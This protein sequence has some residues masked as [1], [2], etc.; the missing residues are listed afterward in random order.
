MLTIVN[1]CDRYIFAF[2]VLGK[3]LARKGHLSD[4][5]EFPV[6]FIKI[7]STYMKCTKTEKIRVIHPGIH[8]DRQK[9]NIMIRELFSAYFLCTDFGTL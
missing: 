8:L 4:R 9:H 6:I 1:Q 3:S 5:K 2:T 7:Q